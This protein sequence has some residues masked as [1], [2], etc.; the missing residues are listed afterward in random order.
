[1]N[2][3]ICRTEMVTTP[4][5]N[6]AELYK[7]MENIGVYTNMKCCKYCLGVNRAGLELQH[8]R[9]FSLRAREADAI[10]KSYNELLYAVETKHDGE[11]RHE[12]ALRYIKET[13][14]RDNP[15]QVEKDCPYA[16]HADDCDC[17]GMGGDR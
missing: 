4:G 8:I 11:T 6:P 12:T 17:Q 5:I 7:W 10:R 2:C 14:S 9:E 3:P 13:E 16:M 15:P 1:M